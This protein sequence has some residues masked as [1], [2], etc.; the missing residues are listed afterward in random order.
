MATH[1]APWNQ[2]GVTVVMGVAE[3]SSAGGPLL[4]EPDARA[5]ETLR[6]VHFPAATLIPG[7]VP[8]LGDDFWNTTLTRR[9]P[10]RFLV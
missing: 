3:E 10:N 5:A 1:D 6:H 9:G 4:L 7:D 2:Q 8:L